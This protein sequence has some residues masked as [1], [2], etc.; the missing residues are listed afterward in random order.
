MAQF[1]SS[2]SAHGIWSLKQQRKSVRGENWPTYEAPIGSQLWRLYVYDP[3]TNIYDLWDIDNGYIRDSGN[4]DLVSAGQYS[5]IL[6]P[7]SALGQYGIFT[8]NSLDPFTDSV[9]D[10]GS[11][12][13]AGPDNHFNGSR[14]SWSPIPIGTWIGIYFSE[15]KT[16][17]VMSGTNISLRT[18]VGGRAGRCPVGM[19]FQYYEGTL[20]SNY[21][22]D[23]WV[24]YA[25]L[26]NV[27]QSDGDP[28]FLNITEGSTIVAS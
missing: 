8:S 21:S 26:T 2:S 23:N 16:T 19:Y 17:E 18:Y 6:E 15:F 5:G 24:T 10:A 1:P 28:V 20:G 13:D 14:T 4:N 25:T 7:G 22:S 11:G 12:W 9:K 27:A 3:P